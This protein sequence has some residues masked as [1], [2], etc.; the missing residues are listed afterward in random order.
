MDG[1]QLV[2]AVRRGDAGTVGALLEAGAAPDTVTADGLPVLCLAVA[3]YDTAVA[4]ELVEGGADPARDV[5]VRG[6]SCS[7]WDGHPSASSWTSPAMWSMTVSRMSVQADSSP[8][9]RWLRVRP[10]VMA[11]R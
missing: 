11:A 6:A 4:Y 1:A 3:A 2:A 9:T 7:R 5:L 8:R 10:S